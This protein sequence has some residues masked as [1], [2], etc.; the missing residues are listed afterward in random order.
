MHNRND[1][2]KLQNLQ[3]TKDL[4]KKQHKKQNM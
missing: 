3:E 1:L 2:E 4:Q